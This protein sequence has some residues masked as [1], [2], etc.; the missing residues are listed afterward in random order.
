M[1]I[2]NERRLYKITVF[3]SGLNYISHLYHLILCFFT[4]AF[5]YYNSLLNTLSVVFKD[6]VLNILNVRTITSIYFLENNN[7][8]YV[9]FNKLIVS[10]C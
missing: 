5:F 1:L 9:C 8:I 7:G 10:L 2:D 6:G 3:K 4:C